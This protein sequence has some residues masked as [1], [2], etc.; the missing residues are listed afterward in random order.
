M[1]AYQVNISIEQRENMKK[2]DGYFEFILVGTD[3]KI[4]FAVGAEFGYCFLKILLIKLLIRSILFQLKFSN[5]RRTYEAGN[6]YT[7][8]IYA[9]PPAVSALREAK[10]KWR[11]SAI[12]PFPKKPIYVKY[13]TVRRIPMLGER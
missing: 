4:T 7:L 10:V 12:F 9:P 6:A 1:H 3:N 2:M 8:I 11:S 5:T 13:I